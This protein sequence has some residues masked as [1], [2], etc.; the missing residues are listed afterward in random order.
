MF[1]KGADVRELFVGTINDFVLGEP[2]HY[3]YKSTDNGIDGFKWRSPMFMPKKAS[4]F[5]TTIK[6]LRCE[7]LQN[8]CLAD[9]Q[10]EGILDDRSTHNSHIQISKFE[11]LWNSI[12]PKSYWRKNDYV[13]VIGW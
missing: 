2:P 6:V 5:K 10:S 3:L 11:N 13:W 8:I 4:R 12:N 7:R 9:I 1:A